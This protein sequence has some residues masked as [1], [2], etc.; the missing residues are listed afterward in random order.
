MKL[1]H[2]ACTTQPFEFR[3]L[4]YRNIEKSPCETDIANRI[5]APQSRLRNLRSKD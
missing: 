5:D 4:I 1:A 2:T 3:A